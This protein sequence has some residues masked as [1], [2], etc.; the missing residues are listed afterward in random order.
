[1]SILSRI[2]RFLG[3]PPLRKGW[4]GD[5]IAGTSV[6]LMFLCLVLCVTM[7]HNH[8]SGSRLLPVVL[9]IVAG[10]S[11][12]VFIW[13][14][15]GP[16]GFFALSSIVSSTVTFALLDFDLA[17][18]VYLLPLFLSGCFCVILGIRHDKM[19]TADGEQD[20]P[21]DAKRPR[22]RA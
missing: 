5:V 21:A 20:A 19:D 9:L 13:I 22:R 3:R 11:C 14:G 8:Y 15:F 2:D 1:M 6:L 16:Y 4:L 10:L 12:C 18:L 17:S 7:A